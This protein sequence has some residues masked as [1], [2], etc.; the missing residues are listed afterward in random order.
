MN[1]HPFPRSGSRPMT[2]ALASLSVAILA[3]C[4][5]GGAETPKA[6]SSALRSPVVGEECPFGSPDT[7]ATTTLNVMAAHYCGNNPAA[8]PSTCSAYYPSV[9][10]L[11]EVRVQLP[12]AHA[13]LIQLWDGTAL[14]E[15]SALPAWLTTSVSGNILDWSATDTALVDHQVVGVI[16]KNGGDTHV[17]DY[18]GTPTAGGD[19]ALYPPHPGN[20]ILNWYNVCF[21]AKPKVTEKP[22][23]CSPGYWKNHTEA[24]TISQSLKYTD[25]FAASTLSIKTH[26]RDCAD[27]NAGASIYEVISKPQCYGGEAANKVADLLSAKYGL[28]FTGER[29]EN[30]P[31]N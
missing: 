12:P 20:T 29:V 23:W 27:A 9:A 3:A 5:G 10:G 22:Q 11:Q 18:S 19:T 7:P 1:S 2:W 13:S 16:L 15:L 30:C 4:G 26:G 6:T 25:Y 28:N 8:P 21:V 31:L 17:Y 24:W 14:S